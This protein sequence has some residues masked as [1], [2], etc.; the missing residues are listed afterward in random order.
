MHSHKIVKNVI[1]HWKH[2]IPRSDVK[3]I[4]PKVIDLFIF[5]NLEEWLVSIFKNPYHMKR[6]SDFDTFLTMKQSSIDRVYLDYKTHKCINLDD[7]GKT[8]FEIRYYK[9]QKIME[10]AK[11]R[12]VI[13]LNLDFIQNESNLL[14]FLQQLS[15]TYNIPIPNYITKI[16]HTKTRDSTINREYNVS[17]PRFQSIIYKCKNTEIEK[18]IK[19]INISS[20]RKESEQTRFAMFSGLKPAHFNTFY[21]SGIDTSYIIETGKI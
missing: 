17:I 9:F 2:A 4:E 20:N 7:N 19:N 13:I 18:F 21:H 10:Y 11:H 5:R 6:V 14:Y 16:P 1:H 8:I 3:E 15:R 12:D